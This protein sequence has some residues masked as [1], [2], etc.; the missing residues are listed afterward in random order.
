M[1]VLKYLWIVLSYLDILAHPYWQFVSCERLNR[2]HIKYQYH[3]DTSIYNQPSKTKQN[4]LAQLTQNK[5]KTCKTSVHKAPTVGRVLHQDRTLQSTN[6]SKQ[7]SNF[8][9]FY[10]T[11]YDLTDRTTCFSKNSWHW[12]L[13]HKHNYNCINFPLCIIYCWP[14]DGHLSQR[15]AAASKY[16]HINIH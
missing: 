10:F 15:H 9:N 16:V 1:F 7:S 12:D 5:T 6:F 14:E 2:Q 3:P 13:S 4:K 8:F 11:L